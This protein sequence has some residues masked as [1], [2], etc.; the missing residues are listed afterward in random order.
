MMREL[1]LRKRRAA[2]A[3]MRQRENDA[4]T[5]FLKVVESVRFMSLAKGLVIGEMMS[6][7]KHQ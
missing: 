3:Q 5:D 6:M 1:E 4:S 2:N 7:V